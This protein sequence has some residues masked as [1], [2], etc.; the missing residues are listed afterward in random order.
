MKSPRES[1]AERID[2]VEKKW[3]RYEVLKHKTLD[4]GSD[5]KKDPILE[6]LHASIS[7]NPDLS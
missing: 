1:F 3:D 2:K 7:K 4:I 6:D 5:Q